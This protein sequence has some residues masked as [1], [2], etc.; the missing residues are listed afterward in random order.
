MSILAGL[1][2]KWSA[3]ALDQSARRAVL[4]GLYDRYVSKYV[5][6][7]YTHHAPMKCIKV[8][9]H[10]GGKRYGN[11]TII[12]APTVHRCDNTVPMW[13]A[14]YKTMSS[15]LSLPLPYRYRT[16]YRSSVCRPLSP[17]FYGK[18]PIYGNTY[19]MISIL[20]PIG[21]VYVYAYRIFEYTYIYRQIALDDVLFITSCG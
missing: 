19:N 2:W 13:F 20:V 10:C 7:K 16:V 17:L 12:G 4:R 15:I 18:I 21:N 3:S 11:D 1:K 14:S 6:A 8:R 9:T 5:L